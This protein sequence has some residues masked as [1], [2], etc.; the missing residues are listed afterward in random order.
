MVTSNLHQGALPAQPHTVQ[1]P[2]TQ[3]ALLSPQS[4][5]R[6]G[7]ARDTHPELGWQQDALEE[8][9]TC[10]A[11]GKGPA[12]CSPSLQ[13]RIFKGKVQE[14]GSVWGLFHGQTCQP[15]LFPPPSSLGKPVPRV[16]GS[17]MQTRWDES[18]WKKLHTPGE[19]HCSVPEPPPSRPPLL[20][21]G[22]GGS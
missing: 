6:A 5:H 21:E 14:T 12:G 10:L 4:Q 1:K 13:Q 18:C 7:T 16:I 17:D 19:P 8:Q 2:Q 15:C 9:W 3:A 20:W 11:V 22:P